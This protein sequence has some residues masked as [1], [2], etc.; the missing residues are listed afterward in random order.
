MVKVMEQQGITPAFTICTGD[1]VSNALDEPLW[2]SWFDDVTS[3]TG[4]ASNAPLQI[5]I[6]NHERHEDCN[7]DTFADR[8]PFQYKP[9]FYYSFNYSST[10]FLM[11][12]PWNEHFLL[13]G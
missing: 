10:H 11:V 13:V 12:D 3:R 1:T 2:E 7:G 6:G 8:Y 5:A 4:L 9:H